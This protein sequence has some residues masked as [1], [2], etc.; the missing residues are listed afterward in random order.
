MT[1]FDDDEEDPEIVDLQPTLAAQ[2]PKNVRNSL[3]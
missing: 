3:L 2:V 1:S